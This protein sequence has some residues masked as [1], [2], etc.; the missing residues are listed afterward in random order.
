MRDRPREELLLLQRHWM[1]AKPGPLMMATKGISFMVV[2]YRLLWSVIEATTARKIDL[3]GAFNADITEVSPKLR[4]CRHA[5][6]HVPDATELLDER[7]ADL[8]G[9][10]SATT[11]RRI[12]RGCG[13]LFHEEMVRRTA[14]KGPRSRL[15]ISPRRRKR[16]MWLA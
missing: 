8:V 15:Q 10:V 16:Q 12:H 4:K 2:W 13:R 5:I 7:I 9:S 6:M 11:I 1:W 14:E 3:R